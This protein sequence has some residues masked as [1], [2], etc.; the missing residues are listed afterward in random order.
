MADIS[1]AQLRKATDEIATLIEDRLPLQMPP[2]DMW[3]AVAH[4]FLARGGTLLES[5]T[6]QVERGMPGEAQMLLRILFEHVATFCWI[7]INPEAHIPQWREWADYRSYQIHKYAKERFGIE[8]LTP[9]QATKAEKAKQ[10]IKLHKLMGGVDE[11][12]SVVSPAFRSYDP[13]QPDILTFTGVYTAVYSKTS[14]LVHADPVSVERF[15]TMP[16]PGEATIHAREKRS[17]SED[18]ASFGLAM[19][20]FL[21]VAF[22]HHFSWPARDVIDGV[23]NGLMP[24]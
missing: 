24:D 7:G 21:L 16:L 10:P 9:A 6:L 20:G 2:E 23:T 14:N 5:V 1:P 12:W 11:H 8:R 18:Y 17:E 19:M 3:Q 13:A 22:E 4:G 15:M